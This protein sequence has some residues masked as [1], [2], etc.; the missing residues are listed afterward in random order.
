[1]DSSLAPTVHRYFVFFCTLVL[2]SFLLI[3]I[4]VGI[5]VASNNEPDG[6]RLITEIPMTVGMAFFCIF[7]LLFVTRF[8]ISFLELIRVFK[9]DHLFLYGLGVILVYG[10]IIMMAIGSALDI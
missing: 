9:K 3:Y 4:G 2:T 7:G 10:F 1:M 8:V 5:G 6:M